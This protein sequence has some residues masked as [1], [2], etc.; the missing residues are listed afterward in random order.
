M[1]FPCYR[2]RSTQ[3]MLKMKHKSEMHLSDSL[4]GSCMSSTVIFHQSTVHSWD[5]LI[6]RVSLYRH[7]PV[8][9]NDWTKFSRGPLGSAHCVFI[10]LSRPSNQLSV[11][12]PFRLYNGH[13]LHSSLKESTQATFANSANVA[14]IE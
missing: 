8:W 1:V 12:P 10:S 13:G 7:N 14:I 5:W 6:K 11:K 2:P 9:F 3:T 4:S